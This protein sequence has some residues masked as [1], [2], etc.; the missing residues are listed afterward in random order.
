MDLL[1]L[2]PFQKAWLLNAIPINR[3]ASVSYALRPG[4]RVVVIASMQFIDLDADFQTKLPNQHSPC[5]WF[6]HLDFGAMVDQPG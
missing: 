5:L 3:L 1:L 6:K 4:D 2:Y